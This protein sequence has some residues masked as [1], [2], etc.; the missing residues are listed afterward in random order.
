MRLIKNLLT[1]ELL[2]WLKLTH[3]HL[4]NPSEILIDILDLENNKVEENN[5]VC[6]KCCLASPTKFSARP[7]AICVQACFGVTSG[8]DGVHFYHQP[9]AVV[10]RE[11]KSN[12]LRMTLEQELPAKQ[13][14]FLLVL[15][16]I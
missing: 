11:G 2:W 9:T 8:A 13:S 12:Q 7:K 16:K 5:K 6:L 14:D 1:S 4:I 10:S 15:D 3:F